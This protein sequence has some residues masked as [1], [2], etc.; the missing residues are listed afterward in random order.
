MKKQFTIIAIT[1]M[2]FVSISACKKE[3]IDISDTTWEVVCPAPIDT[4]N[5]IFHNDHT[6]NWG[7][8]WSQS[9]SNVEFDVLSIIFTDTIIFY[10]TGNR[11]GATMNGTF[12]SSGGGSN[13]SPWTANKE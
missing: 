13:T 10:F 11:D 4:F 7:G 8:S 6:N 2:V 12:T 1:L 3:V 5:I 9:N